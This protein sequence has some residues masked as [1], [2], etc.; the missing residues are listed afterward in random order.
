MIE[1]IYLYQIIIKIILKHKYIKFTMS[2]KKVP[3]FT[4]GN[5]NQPSKI[6]IP[7]D[8]ITFVNSWTGDIL[9]SHP[10]F[11]TPTGLPIGHKNRF[12]HGG[13]KLNNEDVIVFH[14]IGQKKK[15]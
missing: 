10:T 3:V 7:T 8:N 4:T 2:N 6:Y 15:L 13:I 14:G 5:I 1:Y 9:D 11:S 12:F